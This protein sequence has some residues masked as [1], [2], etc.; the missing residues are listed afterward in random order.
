MNDDRLDSENDP[1]KPPAIA[2]QVSC[3][4]CREVYDS[5]LIEWRIEKTSDGSAHGFWCCPMPA[6]NGRGFGFDIFPI[7]PNYRDEDGEAMWVEDE[8][9]E[10]DEL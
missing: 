4:H 8:E 3:L 7:D 1:F 6:C 10:P 9:T 5:Y 2:T